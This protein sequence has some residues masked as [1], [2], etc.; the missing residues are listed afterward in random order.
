MEAMAF[1]EAKDKIATIKPYSGYRF[2]SWDEATRIDHD[3]MVD[4]FQE[5]AELYA[6]SLAARAWEEGYYARKQ[7]DD[8]YHKEIGR[9]VRNEGQF[10]IDKDEPKN[11]YKD[12]NIA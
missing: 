4:H 6:R 2:S 5:A 11:P 7:Y 1:E 8:E 10:L 9:F 12:E 3:F